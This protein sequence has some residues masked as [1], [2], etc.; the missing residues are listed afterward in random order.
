MSAMHH[1]TSH[2]L[3]HLGAKLKDILGVMVIHM[4]KKEG[5]LLDIIFNDDWFLIC[6]VSA[7]SRFLILLW[8]QD[9]SLFMCATLSQREVHAWLLL[10]Y[11][12]F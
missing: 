2:D 11:M 7:Y 9:T 8:K 12:V 4:F 3:K 10:V 1:D 5:I 6:Y